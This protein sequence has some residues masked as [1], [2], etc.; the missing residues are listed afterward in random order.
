MLPAQLTNTATLTGGGDGNPNNNTASIPFPIT[1][2]VQL[3]VLGPATA[4]AAAGQSSTF[5]VQVATTASTGAVTFACSGLPTG[6]ACSFSPSSIAPVPSITPVNVVISTTARTASV[7]GWRFDQTPQAP[8]KPVLL[9]LLGTV[10]A[11]VFVKRKRPLLRWAA[12]AA[13]LLLA[14]VLVGCGGG[15][16]TPQVVQNPNGTPP[17]T[18][19]ITVSATGA[20]TGSATQVFTLT[21]R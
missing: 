2:A 19:A 16:S 10:A 12:G 3:A 6:A 8:S 13:S 15:S 4:S 9:L 18:F 1:P 11:M 21:V 5:S 7:F 14:A 17:G 20:T